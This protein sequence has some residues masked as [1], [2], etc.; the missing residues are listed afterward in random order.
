MPEGVN[1]YRP[2]QPASD[3]KLFFGRRDLLTSIR[4]QLMKGRRGFVV[5][6][7]ARI[8]KTS[9]LRQ[10]PAFLPGEF[11]A[12]LVELREENAQR[13]DWLL[14]RI[15]VAVSQQM[16]RDLGAELSEP[17]WSDFEGASGRLLD[18][19]WPEVR[20]LLGDRCL[21]MLLD[22]LDIEFS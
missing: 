1:P 22:D 3:P 18:H 6:G 8:G 16:G 2:G 4:E 7:A 13:L 10:M 12:A 11:L 9:L 19:F 17:A 15:A 14:W 21:V 20:A 5:L